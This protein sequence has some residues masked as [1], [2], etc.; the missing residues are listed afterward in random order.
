MAGFGG[1]IIQ[2]DLSARKIKTRSIPPEVIEDFIGGSGLTARL[3]HDRLD[4]DV[5]PLGPENPLLFMTGPMV[6][7]VMPSAGRCSAR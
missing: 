2:I 3:L 1:N 5:D 6:G 4:Q 7:T